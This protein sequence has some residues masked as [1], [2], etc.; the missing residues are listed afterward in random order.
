MS[1]PRRRPPLADGRE[2]WAGSSEVEPVRSQHERDA[3][4]T[5]D[6]ALT[7]G[8]DLGGGQVEP[9]HLSRRDFGVV[10]GAPRLGSQ[11]RIHPAFQRPGLRHFGDRDDM[12]L[13]AASD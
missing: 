1:T 7:P 11:T 13:S 4:I 9:N 12:H 8:G 10:I 2:R 5:T 3:G 6:R